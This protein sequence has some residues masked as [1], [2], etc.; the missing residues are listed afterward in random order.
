[1]RCDKIRD[2]SD[3]T[4][5]INSNLGEL[6][7]VNPD[8]TLKW[9]FFAGCDQSAPSIGGDHT[10]YF[11]NNCGGKVYA[12]QSD[13]SVKWSYA[14]NGVYIRSSPAIGMNQEIYV[15]TL[16]FISQGGVLAFGQ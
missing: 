14:R 4:V 1:M 15:S 7:A 5:Y 10:I 13:G 2:L 6:H 8:G 12:L 3:G 11:T 9:K 16:G